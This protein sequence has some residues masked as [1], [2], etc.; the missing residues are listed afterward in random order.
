ML[1]V[2]SLLGTGWKI[3]DSEKVTVSNQSQMGLSSPLPSFCDSELQQKV[4]KMSDAW[5]GQPSYAPPVGWTVYWV[6]RSAGASADALT[7]KDTLWV[8]PEGVAYS[9]SSCAKSI[10]SDSDAAIVATVTTQ[11][12]NTNVWLVLGLLGLVAYFTFKN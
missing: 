9:M 4:T 12:N 10:V 1:D 2:V 11:P 5:S 3:D 7:L 6:S 8:S